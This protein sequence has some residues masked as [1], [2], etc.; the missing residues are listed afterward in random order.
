MEKNNYIYRYYQK[1]KDGSVIVGKWIEL[2]FEYIVNGIEN[3]DFYFDQKKANDAIRFIQSKC[4][5]SEG[6]LAPNCLKLE[7]WQ[8]AIVSTIFGCVDEN[9]HRQFNTCL[10]VV[11]RKNGKTL[12]ASS[13]IQ[14]MI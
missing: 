6:A 11:G 4:H 1:I 8:K 13:I 5:H 3:K 14:Q 10:I 12:L 2:A 7:L 9:G